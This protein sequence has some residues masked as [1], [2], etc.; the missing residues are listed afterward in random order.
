M[1]RKLTKA[2]WSDAYFQGAVRALGS[3]VLVGLVSLFGMFVLGRGDVTNITLIYL[4]AIAAASVWLGYRPSLL[5][6]LSGAL[7]LDYYFLPPYDTFVIGSAR[8]I[9]TFGGMFCTA[10]FISTLNER[11]RRQARAARQSE[12][13]MESLYG[14]TR[15]LV[16]ATSVEELCVR[17]ATQIELAGHQMV[18]VLLRRG[19]A[20]TRAVRPGGVVALENEDI[21]AAS[22][23]AAHLE[24]AGLGTRNCA[25]AGACYVPLIAARGCIGVLSLRPREHERAG[26]T[27]PSSLILSMARQVAL[28]LERA[29]LSEEKQAAQLEIETE[30]IRNSVLSSVSHD[31]RSPLAV[32]ASASSTL[33]ENGEHLQGPARTEM[34]RI[35]YEEAR[36]L[37]E[38]LKSLLDVTRLQAGGLKVSR[39]WESIEEVVGSVLRRVDER[40]SVRQL[41][42]N[43]PSDLPLLQ[44]DA[45]LVVQVLLNLVDNAFK[46][47]GSEQAVDIDVALRGDEVIVSVIDHGRGITDDEL[48]RIFEKFYRSD[49]AP[50]GG[51]GLGL[52]LARGIVQAHGGRIWAKHTAGGGLTI[53][54]TLPLSAAPPRLAGLEVAEGASTQGRV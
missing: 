43:V 51:L 23:A 12:R 30:R 49:D 54:F 19:E 50:G 41:R 6:A 44:L 21:P 20:F 34:S 36:R 7:C 10:V 39:E 47:S 26:Q 37:N 11:L 4:F 38:L 24:P 13:R 14:L 32:I 5:A 1:I 42:A 15:E 35:I 3:L 52:T 18:C 2:L 22:W 45:I 46:H 33:V 31:L 27:R 8:E 25:G 53:Q 9:I 17:A 29:L 40:S 16:D 48:T 28:A